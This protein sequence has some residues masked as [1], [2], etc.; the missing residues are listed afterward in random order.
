VRATI[1]T[2]GAPNSS[3][4]LFARAQPWRHPGSA[5]MDGLTADGFSRKLAEASQ[6]VRSRCAGAPKDTRAEVIDKLN[7]E[8]NAVAA[9]P[10]IK[11]RLAGLGVDPMSACP[12]RATSGIRAADRAAEC[13]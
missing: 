2:H 4:L 1:S 12:F 7:N 11:A 9:D 6:M 8:I 13:C 5:T 3:E 10:L